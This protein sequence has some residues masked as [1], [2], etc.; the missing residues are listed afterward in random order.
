MEIYHKIVFRITKK[1]VRRSKQHK[2]LL[3]GYEYNGN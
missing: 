2:L 3:R 1:I